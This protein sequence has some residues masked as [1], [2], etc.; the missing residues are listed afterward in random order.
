MKKKII[1]RNALMAEQLRRENDELAYLN[2]QLIN[3]QAE[4]QEQKAIVEELNAQLEKESNKNQK[5]KDT[6][7]AIID[8]IETGIAMIDT[9]GKTI[10]MNKF[11]RRIFRY[12]N[13]NDGMH[14][15]SWGNF[16]ADSLIRKVVAG[17]TNA[18]QILARLSESL[19]NFDKNYREELEYSEFAHRYCRISSEPC[20]SS[21]NQALGRIFRFRDITRYKEIDLLKSELISTVSHELRTPMSSIMGFSELLLTRQLSPERSKQYIE[22]IHEQ[23]DRLTKLISDFLDIQRMES[24]KQIFD[25]Q[26]IN[27]EE[28]ISQTSELF[29][30][31]GEKHKIIFNFDQLEPIFIYGDRDK[32]LQVMSNLLSNAIK[33]SPQGGEISIRVLVHDNILQVSITDHGLGIPEE[34]RTKLFE[35]FFRVNNNDRRE[36]G[37][38]GLGL[39]ICKEIIQ[40]HN[41]TIWVESLYGVG[42]TF[43][44]TI[45]LEQPASSEAQ[46]TFLIREHPMINECGKNSILIVEDDENLANLV[47]AIL[48]EDGFTIHTVNSGEE[49]LRLIDQVNYKII[50]LDIKLAGKLTG[51]DV[52]K[53]L[54]DNKKTNHIPVVISSIYENNCGSLSKDIS[55]YLVKPFKLEQLL[56]VVHKV[57]NE[58]VKAKMFMHGDESLDKHLEK[59]LSQNGI[60]VKEIKSNDC[61]FMITLEGDIYNGTKE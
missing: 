54:K 52:V 44:F 3:K 29:G 23:A 55:D 13:G 31:T 28:V 48:K 8:S 4:L 12:D 22:I 46:S 21:D 53:A 36:I 14:T 33:Y 39:A 10:F 18:E 41:G 40:A 5:Q 45:P 60:R 25:K 42:S 2:A 34:A 20:H 59:I 15:S 58:S 37:G 50:I 43:H 6:L 32:L 26:R 35:K 57:M 49:A 38:T 17:S 19:D 30:N 61:I 1:Y 9:T 16:D 51:W 24:G 7:Q 47:E 56:N 11:W 27:F